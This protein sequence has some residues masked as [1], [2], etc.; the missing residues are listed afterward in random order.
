MFR[1]VRRGLWE[2]VNM[3]YWATVRPCSR[4]L[5]L[6]GSAMPAC[7]GWF[8]GGCPR[9]VSRRQLA[10]GIGLRSVGFKVWGIGV[11]VWGLGFGHWATVGPC[12]RCLSLRGSARRACRNRWIFRGVTGKLVYGFRVGHALA[13][14]VCHRQVACR[15]CRGLRVEGLGVGVSEQ[16]ARW[17]LGSA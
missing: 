9:E 17:G 6:R 15:G 10:Y 8:Q 12:F 4:C 1:G 2:A 7:Q 16:R 11:R 14:D 13:S 3:R 5:S